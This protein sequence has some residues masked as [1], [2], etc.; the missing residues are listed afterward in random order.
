MTCDVCSVEIAFV[1][2]IRLGANALYWQHYFSFT[3]RHLPFVKQSFYFFFIKQHLLYYIDTNILRHVNIVPRRLKSP[4]YWAIFGSTS[5][6]FGSVFFV[7]S[8]NGNY[9]II[10][11]GF[12]KLSVINALIFTRACFSSL[13]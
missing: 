6:G 4:Y 11:S 1:N 8:R 9:C 2:L 13:P 7:R 10:P 12:A 5:V 3:N